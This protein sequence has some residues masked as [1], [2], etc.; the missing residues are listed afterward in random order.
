MVGPRISSPSWSDALLGKDVRLFQ[1]LWLVSYHQIR[2]SHW[3]SISLLTELLLAASW[4]LSQ[5]SRQDS[6]HQTF[7]TAPQSPHCDKFSEPRD[8]GVWH[9]DS[10]PLWSGMCLFRASIW[11][12]MNIWRVSHPMMCSR[13]TEAVLILCVGWRPGFWHHWSR[14]P[15]MWSRPVFSSAP[16]QKVWPPS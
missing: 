2:H 10:E 16:T 11:C 5:W 8:F 14:N 7:T 4:S 1:G 12:F 6:S 15:R 3:L 13:H 9:G